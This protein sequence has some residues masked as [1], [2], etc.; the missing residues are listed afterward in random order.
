MRLCLITC[1]FSIGKTDWT[2]LREALEKKAEPRYT[3][4]VST[5]RTISFVGFEMESLCSNRNTTTVYRAF[6]KEATVAIAESLMKEYCKVGYLRHA[7][8]TKTNDYIGIDTLRKVSCTEGN[9]GNMNLQKDM[10]ARKCGLS[11]FGFSQKMRTDVVRRFR[12]YLA[13][14]IIK[15]K[16]WINNHR[17]FSYAQNTGEIPIWRMTP[18]LGQMKSIQKYIGLQRLYWKDYSVLESI[19]YG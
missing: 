14:R 11:Q 16:Y 3:I 8:G 13:S 15:A 7:L 6:S 5:S 12:V 19:A 2:F 4:I 9:K 10:D 1:A 18:L 17:C